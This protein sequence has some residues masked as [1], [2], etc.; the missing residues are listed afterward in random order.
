MKKTNLP[1]ILDSSDYLEIEDCKMLKLSS[2][3]SL[4]WLKTPEN[5]SFR[6]VCGFAGEQSFT[7]RKETS[8]KGKADYWYGYRK[9]DGKLHK[10]YI[11]KAEDITRSRLEEIANALDAPAPPRVK[12]ESYIENYV[13]KESAQPQIQP[14]SYI[15][16]YVTQEEHTA[17]QQRC[18]Q[19]LD[20]LEQ[21]RRER[22]RLAQELAACQSSQSQLQQP[23]YEVIRDRTLAG[24]RL[25]KQAPGYKSAKKVLDDFIS[26]LKA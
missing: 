21:L 23:D 26:R 10:R 20:E 1:T 16:N 5:R 14:S 6:F 8:K 25:G 3:A 15:E 2:L 17:C 13:T 9:V 24:L 19:L 11:G 12:A 7:A 18:E 4:K 22:D